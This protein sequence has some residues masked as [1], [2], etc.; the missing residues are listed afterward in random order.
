MIIVDDKLLIAIK[1]INNY[2]F[3]NYRERLKKAIPNIDKYQ[4]LLIEDTLKD[5]YL[6]KYILVN[7]YCDEFNNEFKDN[8][9]LSI[10]NQSVDELWHLHILYTK[11]Y[12]EF[13]N[14]FFGFYLHHQPT[15]PEILNKKRLQ[16][17]NNKLFIMGKIVKEYR[18]YNLSDLNSHKKHKNFSLLYQSHK[19]LTEIPYETVLNER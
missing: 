17:E 10:P 8:L 4:I 5:F 15:N 12:F 9:S 3:L 16:I 18:E 19:F 6:S 2:K 14:D 13:C 1:Y 11:E 7:G